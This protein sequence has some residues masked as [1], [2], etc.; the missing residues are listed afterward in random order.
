MHVLLPALQCL[1]FSHDPTDPHAAQTAVYGDACT[2]RRRAGGSPAQRKRA[3]RECAESRWRESL[4]A[5]CG[6]W[7]S[8]TNA[9]G[10]GGCR[11]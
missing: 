5:V 3:L 1:L 9:D 7:R 2:V 6:D 4:A 10:C 11:R 8:I